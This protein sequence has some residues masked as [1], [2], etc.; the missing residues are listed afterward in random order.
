MKQIGSFVFKKVNLSFQLQFSFFSVVSGIELPVWAV[1]S[2]R[3]SYGSI[4]K[5]IKFI[6]RTCN[7]P[8][9]ALRYLP[10]IYLT[11]LKL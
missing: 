4:N 7:V 11:F 10:G 2:E 5:E 3:S 1:L 8:C 9:V 6:G